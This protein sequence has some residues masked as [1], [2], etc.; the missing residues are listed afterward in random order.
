MTHHLINLAIDINKGKETY[1]VIRSIAERFNYN[2]KTNAFDNILQIRIITMNNF[3]STFEFISENA[4]TNAL[5][6]IKE[7]KAVTIS[8]IAEFCSSAI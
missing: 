4:A 7:R 2:N 5:L 6:T 1:G 3:I 8:K